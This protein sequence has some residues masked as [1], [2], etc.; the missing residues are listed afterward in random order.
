MLMSDDDRTIC[1]SRGE[2]ETA[3]EVEDKRQK[4]SKQRC[5]NLFSFSAAANKEATI[6]RNRTD[7][8]R[9]CGKLLFPTSNQYAS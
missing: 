3:K 8:C 9:G 2:E 4:K 5:G 6:K 7:S 1:V